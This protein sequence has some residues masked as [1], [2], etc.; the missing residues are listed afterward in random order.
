[1]N[2]MT[3]VKQ[4]SNVTV[5]NTVEN[6]DNVVMPCNMPLFA[7]DTNIPFF[8]QRKISFY[9]F[10]LCLDLSKAQC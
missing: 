2:K 5:P 10:N 6:M 9:M 4:K 8:I 1:M 3:S 7:L